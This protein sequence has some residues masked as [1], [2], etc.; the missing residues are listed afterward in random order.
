MYIS[1][2]SKH[3]CYL[4]LPIIFCIINTVTGKQGLTAPM[5]I[6]K[7]FSSLRT[8]E[9]LPSLEQQLSLFQNFFDFQNCLLSKEGRKK[10][11]RNRGL[12]CMNWQKR[13]EG[14]FWA[15][16]KTMLEIFAAVSIKIILGRR[17][18]AK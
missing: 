2:L 17:C 8:P 4:N 3:P 6:A 1:L 10:F 9:L 14:S 18:S 5:D 15:T 11:S 13:T 12:D 7:M 16:Q